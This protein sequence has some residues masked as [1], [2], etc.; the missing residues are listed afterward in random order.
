MRKDTNLME[1]KFQSLKKSELEIS[2]ISY[3]EKVILC[4]VLN[5]HLANLGDVGVQSRTSAPI[6]SA[7][8]KVFDL[9]L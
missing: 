9:S 4:V 7:R 2:R 6:G 3:G 1:L 5:Y 8:L